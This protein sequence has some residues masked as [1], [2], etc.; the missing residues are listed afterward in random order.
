M[1]T[2]CFL[3]RSSLSGALLVV[4]VNRSFGSRTSDGRATRRG[5]ANGTKREKRVFNE[6]V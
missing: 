2:L 1:G 3:R 5:E 4:A 6:A